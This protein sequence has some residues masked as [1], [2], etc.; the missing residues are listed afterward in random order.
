MG[1]LEDKIKQDLMQ[2]IFTSNLKTFETIDSKF[3]LNDEDKSKV[4][5]LVS[6]FN[7]E[8]NKLLKNAKLS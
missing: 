4:L 3:K 6:K 5:D 7:E 2:T 8:L 1:L